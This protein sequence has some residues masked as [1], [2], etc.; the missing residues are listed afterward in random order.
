MARNKTTGKQ[1]TYHQME[2][3]LREM[4]EVVQQL[5]ERVNNLEYGIF[6]YIEF[7]KTGKKFN[8]WMDKRHKEAQ[9]KEEV[10]NAIQKNETTVGKDLEG[11]TASQGRGTEGIRT[12]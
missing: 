12:P 2:N 8:K 4:A 3:V 6:S 9:A 5:M 7:R 10:K 1:L 11:T